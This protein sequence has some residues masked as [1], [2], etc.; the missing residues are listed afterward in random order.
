[1]NKKSSQHAALFITIVFIA[2]TALWQNLQAQ[3]PPTP[4][5]QPLQLYVNGAYVHIPAHDQPAMLKDYW[6]WVP[7]R[8]AMEGL[9]YAVYWDDYH[10]QGT[11]VGPSHTITITLGSDRVYFNEHAFMLDAPVQVI[12]NRAMVM[13]RALADLTLA[14]IWVNNTDGIVFVRARQP[15]Q[16]I[17]PVVDWP[18]HL[19][20]HVP[21]SIILEPEEN[22]R[23]LVL[24]EA[25]PLQFRAAFYH[26]PMQILTLVSADDRRV[27]H[28]T[29]GRDSST[30]LVVDFIQF[31]D[32]SRE[33]F[34][35]ALDSIRRGAQR[36]AEDGYININDEMHEVFNADIIFTFDH[37]IIRY[38]Y[39]RE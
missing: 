7:L 32:I 6:L 22:F 9:G 31:F 10:R 14:T 8:A 2:L 4:H 30:M 37:D 27:W 3:E 34:E 12:N 33:D 26:I 28:D 23:G 38:F 16:P 5:I 18:E 17:V 35:N 25:F 13:A 39:R 36:L 29:R 21:G 11:I 1:M 15:Q 19:P 24:D 20:R